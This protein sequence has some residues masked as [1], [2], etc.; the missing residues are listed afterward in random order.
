MSTERI[1]PIYTHRPDAG[2]RI[3]R[4]D[5]VI[6][7]AFRNWQGW[8]SA[9]WREELGAITALHETKEAAISAVLNGAQA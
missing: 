5:R 4:D 7:T 3:I 6:G 2:V 9:I 1:E 8:C